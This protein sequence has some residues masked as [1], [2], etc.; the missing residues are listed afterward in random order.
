MRSK[1]LK[2]LVLLNNPLVNDG[3]VLKQIRALNRHGVAIH[4]LCLSDD[5]ASDEFETEG[6]KVLRLPGIFKIRSVRHVLNSAGTRFNPFSNLLKKTIRFIRDNFGALILTGNFSWAAL[7]QK[8]IDFSQ[9]DLIHAH[10]LHTLH[11]ANY[12]S[13]KYRIP[14][15]YDAHEFET[16]NTD[17]TPIGKKIIDKIERKYAK[18]AAHVITVSDDIADYLEKEYKIT[19]P[20]IIYN[21]PEKSQVHATRTVKQELGLIANTPLVVCIGNFTPPRGSNEIMDAFA[22]AKEAHLAVVGSSPT[23]DSSIL[24][25]ANEL[26][27]ADRIHLIKKQPSQ[28]LI[29]FIS[30]ADASLILYHVNILNHIYA[31]PNKLFESAFAGLPI[32]YHSQLLSIAHFMNQ[33]QIGHAIHSHDP[34]AIASA[35]Q[36]VAGHKNDYVIDQEKVGMIKRSYEWEQQIDKL[37]SIYEQLTHDRFSYMHQPSVDV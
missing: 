26:D 19:R 36:N 20:Q 27:I 1:P 23:Y 9:F 29:H 16:H 6:A 34:A 24:A 35:I 30:D 15:I 28:S 17:L 5:N 21:T 25:Y 10:D 2:V 7:R 3:R 32:I 13:K 4:V 8:T 37:K 22:I 12:L 33:Y 11:A 14:F 31:M 18:N